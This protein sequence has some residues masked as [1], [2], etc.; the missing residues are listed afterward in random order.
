MI[1]KMVHYKVR[2]ENLEEVRQAI[3]DFVVGI[4]TIEPATRYDA[5]QGEDEFSFVHWMAFPGEKEEKYHQSAPHTMKFVDILYPS[6]EQMPVF[7][8]LK[9]LHSTGT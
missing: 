5:Y 7:T 4:A 8:D 6:C 3:K 9:L 2:P 1:I